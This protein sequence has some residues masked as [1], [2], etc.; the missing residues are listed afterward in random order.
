LLNSSYCTPAAVTRRAG[1]GEQLT[2]TASALTRLHGSRAY[3]VNA[4]VQVYFSTGVPWRVNIIT[5]DMPILSSAT[6]TISGFAIATQFRGDQV[7]TMEA[8]YADGSNAGPS[9]WTSFKEFD[10]A[11][12]PDYSPTGSRCGRRSSPR[13]TRAQP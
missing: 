7:A 3:G 11:F 5:Y 8:K 9:N 13:S 4:A 12:A 1:A 6:G 2:F 10:V